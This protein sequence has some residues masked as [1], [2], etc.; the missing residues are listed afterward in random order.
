MCSLFTGIEDMRQLAKEVFMQNWMHKGADKDVEVWDEYYQWPLGV[1]M[2][3]FLLSF[4]RIARGGAALT[5]LL[6]VSF[7]ARAEDLLAAH[8]ANPSDLA[9]AERAAVSLLQSGRTGE[10][11]QLLDDIADRTSDVEQRVRS[12]YNAGLAAYQQGALQ[13]AVNAWDKVLEDNSEHA[14][15]QANSEAVKQEIAQRL[16]EDQQRQQEE[17]SQN[18]ESQES[19]AQESQDSESQSSEQNE[20]QDSESQSEE[21]QSQESQESDA[22]ES[23]DSEAQSAQDESDSQDAQAD[24]SEQDPSESQNDSQALSEEGKW[25]HQIRMHQTKKAFL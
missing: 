19:D 16:A 2:M 11:Y 4:V 12:R 21:S 6:M 23:Q 14:A 15:A 17:Q 3:A 13:D 20:S 10:A 18:Q 7:S 5:V 25:R 22:Q 24:A 9:L 1:A 8:I